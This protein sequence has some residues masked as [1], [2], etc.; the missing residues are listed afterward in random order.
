M[1]IKAFVV[2]TM[3]GEN[4]VSDDVPSFS[5][6]KE[7]QAPSEEQAVY[8]ALTRPGDKWNSDDRDDEGL[9]ELLDRS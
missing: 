2:C 6:S 8:E 4:A 3:F 5:L 7:Y 9:L 1:L